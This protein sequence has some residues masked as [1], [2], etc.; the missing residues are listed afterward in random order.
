M[1]RRALRMAPECSLDGPIELGSR[2][3]TG[4]SRFLPVELT[5]PARPLDPQAEI[6]RTV[7]EDPSSA[8]H[9]CLFPLHIREPLSLRYIGPGSPAG[10]Q[11]N[12]R[13]SFWS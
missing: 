10:L 8:N 5:V 12:F 6:E 11:S 13:V 4:V 3:S 1:D 7:S 9:S 2:S